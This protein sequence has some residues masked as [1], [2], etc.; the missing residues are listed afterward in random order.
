VAVDTSH[1]TSDCRVQLTD[2]DKRWRIQDLQMGTKVERRGSRRRVAERRRREYRGAEGADGGGVWGNAPPHKIVRFWVWKWRL[3]VHS[4]R[5]PTWRGG[6]ARPGPLGSASADKT[7]ETY[8]RSWNCGLGRKQ[9]YTGFHRSVQIC[10]GFSGI[11]PNE[12]FV[13]VCISVSN[14]DI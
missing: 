3:L 7:H 12:L 13:N 5:L 10:K 6:M 11:K 14:V 4:G 1:K 9:K 2:T 8:Y